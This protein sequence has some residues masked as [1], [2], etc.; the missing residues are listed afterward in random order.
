MSASEQYTQ[1]NEEE[2]E[3]NQQTQ[4]GFIVFF[5]SM[6]FSTIVIIMFFGIGSIFLS[7]TNFYS[8]EKMTGRFAD[9]YPYTTRFPYK[10]VFTEST[11]TSWVYRY[12][13]WLTDATIDAFARNRYYL[14]K[15]LDYTGKALNRSPGFVSSIVLVLGPLIMGT[16]ILISA[17]AGVISTI[18]GAVSNL[19]EVIPNLFELVVLILPFCIPLL[20]Y[21]FFIMFS[22]GMLSMGVGVAQAIMML[23]F[24]SFYPL[25]NAKARQEIINTIIKN[26]Y[27]LFL[28][29]FSV[30]T[31]NAFTMLGKTEG[32]ISLGFSLASLLTYIYMS[33]L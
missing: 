27:L 8:Q 26:K 31:A 19:G 12:G 30:M 33:V 3:N 13:R 22:G 24:F 5:V 17:L 25:T 20:I 15:F 4:K 28:C 7:H 21:P 1:K 18:I 9:G 14:D 29:I 16:L 11:D 32:Y 2:T 10:N 6:I 23:G